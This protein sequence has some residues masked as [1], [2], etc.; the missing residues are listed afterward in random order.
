MLRRENV[1]GQR[2]KRI[3]ANTSLSDDE[4]NFADFVCVLGNGFAFR[5]PSDDE[6]GDMFPGVEITDA[7]RPVKFN[8]RRWLHYAY[9][10]WW[11]R[12][13][14]VLVPADP[15]LRFPDSAAIAL[16]SGWYIAQYSGA[17]RGILP[18]IDIMPKLNSGDEMVSVWKT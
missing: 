5:L 4:F 16:S 12:I 2:I 10:L 15:E 1:V 6:S 11:A 7:F 9:R 3:I 13:V 18:L 14:D 8:S 17:P